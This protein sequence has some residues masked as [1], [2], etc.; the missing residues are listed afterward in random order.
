VIPLRD[1]LADMLWGPGVADAV[2]AV[3]RTGIKELA[4]DSVVLTVDEVLA[5][6]GDS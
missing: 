1:E 3:I 5:F 4:G 6:L 2:L